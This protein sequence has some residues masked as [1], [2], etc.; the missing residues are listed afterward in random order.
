MSTMR[1][2]LL[3][4]LTP[5]FHLPH[6]S[7]QNSSGSVSLTTIIGVN[8]TITP[9]IT[10]ATATTT[11]TT[12]TTLTDSTAPQDLN[13]ISIRSV[14][15][16]GYQT[17][18]NSCSHRDLGFTGELQG[19]WYAVYGDTLWAAPGVTDMFNDTPGFHGMPVRHQLQFVPYNEGWGETNR[20]GFGGT[21]ICQVDEDAGAVYYLVNANEAGLIGA[22]IGKVELVNDAPTVTER[23]GAAGYWW[24]ANAAARYGDVC[25]Y[26]DEWSDY[27]Y[28]WGGPPNYYVKDSEDDGWG[29]AAGYGS[30]LARVRARSAFE[31]DEYEYYW[32]REKGWRREVLTTFTPETAALWG[33]GQGQVAWNEHYGCYIFV[34]VGIFGNTVMLRT[35][36]SPEGPWTP[37]IEVYTATPIDGGLVYAGVAHP[38]HDPS[39]NSLVIS[40]TN[41]NHIEVIEVEFN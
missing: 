35:A 6:A 38:Y 23:F 32:G 29:D 26:R 41:N 2:M 34:H 33:T 21:S 12:F 18:N 5:L 22:G 13:P 1:Q 11:Q 10:T 3:Y 40:F 15:W 14:R 28:V 9:T 31:L 20:Y 30:Y 37:D 17:A 24:D 8:S 25:A 36:L 7:C 4:L 16:L 19:K 39:G 27:I